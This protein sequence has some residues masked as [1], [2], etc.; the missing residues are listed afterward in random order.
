M[1]R[2]GAHAEGRSVQVSAGRH[3]G[4]V[5]AATAAGMVL[6]CAIVGFVFLSPFLSG[7]ATTPFGFDTPHY[8]WRSNLVIARGLDGLHA[9]DPVLVVNPN[10]DRP[11]YPV[12][13]ALVDHVAGV[14]PGWLAYVAPSVFAI[15]AGLAA[16]AFGREA[17]EEPL[18][19][20]PVYVILVG[21]SLFVVRTAVGSAD[22]LQADSVLLAGGTAALLFAARRRAGTGAVLVFLGAFLIH[23]IFTGL[24]MALLLGV[25]VVLV[26]YSYRRWSRGESVW[27]TPSA[28]I[29]AVTSFS[30]AGAFL[31]LNQTPDFT[32]KAPVVPLRQIEFKVKVRIPLLRLPFHLAVG[33][34]GLV[35]LWWPRSTLRRL[36]M[37]L[38]GLWAVSVPL[39]FAMY[40][41]RNHHFPIYRVAE[42]ALALPL[43]GSALVVGLVRLGWAKLR[44]VGAVL[45]TVVVVA[46]A[47]ATVSIGRDAW[48]ASPAI[49]TPERVQQVATAATYL[50][51][52]RP[53]GPVIFVASLP[54]RV[55]ADRVIRAGMPGDV[56]GQVRLFVGRSDDLLAGRQSLFPN[57]GPIQGASNV[58][59]PGIEA[60]L[61]QD[62]VAMYLSAL[63]PALPPPR[64]ARMI[65]TGVYVIRGPSTPASVPLA[66][67]P[68]PDHGRLV[69]SAIAVLLYLV[70][71]GLGWSAGLLDAGWLSRVGLAP[72]FG[73]A[74]TTLA[75]APVADLG[76]PFSSA[77]AWAISLATALLGWAVFAGV[78]F[79]RR[80]RR[81]EAQCPEDVVER[82]DTV[83][84]AVEPTV[85][86]TVELGPRPGA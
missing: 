35:A 72:A 1:D 29:G 20:F 64:D 5:T 45:G 48:E 71:T 3:S 32:V 53:S 33:A 31:A 24:F 19:A 84:P 57:G 74:T 17:L 14:D 43:L 16:A 52:V 26:P 65:A 77:T 47:A 80:R 13:A 50:E 83:E 86:P 21:A 69:M 67:L 10:P 82:S 66:P 56:V 38:L 46:A 9:V 4:A 2:N 34:A 27:S 60:V 75:A 63:N 28:R 85:E 73:L 25:A 12:F 70:F 36:A 51:A 11:A 79:V 7:K 23:W 39:G 30:L 68:A 78:A 37:V 22:N 18:W 54:A 59:W 40:A 55:P 6:A 76:R 49:M 58:T 61:D 62:Y 15:C 42:F 81:L 8:A 41:A 44:L